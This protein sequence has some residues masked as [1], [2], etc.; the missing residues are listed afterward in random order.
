MVACH[1]RSWIGP[2]TETALIDCP[3]E[4]PF[5]VEVEYLVPVER[6]D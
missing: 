6:G 4:E 1:F 3:G 2:D 5:Q